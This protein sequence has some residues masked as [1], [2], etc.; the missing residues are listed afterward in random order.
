MYA[1]C[2]HLV[3]DGAIDGTE[4]PWLVEEMSL[5]HPVDCAAKLFD[6]LRLLRRSPQ[7]EERRLDKQ[8]DL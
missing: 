4:S 3:Y 5:L 1:P 7:F 6:L 8:M 2:F